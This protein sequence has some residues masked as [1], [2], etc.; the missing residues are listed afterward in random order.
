[1]KTIYQESDEDA[2]SKWNAIIRVGANSKE[3]D[4]L[5]TLAQQNDLWFH[6]DKGPSCHVYLSIEGTPEKRDVNKLISQCENLVLQ[7]SKCAPTATV[8]HTEKKN[9]KRDHSKSGSII[10]KKTPKS[11]K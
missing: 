8:I 10:L 3:N 2:T 5:F 9:I 6:L 1:M 7:S 4:A 11:N